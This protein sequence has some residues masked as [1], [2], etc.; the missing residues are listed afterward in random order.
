MKIHI[1]GLEILCIIGV[2]D[3]EREHQQ[4][5]L[6]DL[7]IQ[8]PYKERGFLDYSE[9]TSRLETHLKREKYLLLEEALLGIKKI[10]FT[11]FSAIDTLHVKLSKP[12]ILPQC[13]VGL[14]AE[15]VNPK[16]Q[17]IPNTLQ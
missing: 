12:D 8:Y 17:D 4:R 10:L 9:I 14:S 5:V 13:S 6:L 11:E 2:L 1:E 3:F 16:T 15:W 7:E